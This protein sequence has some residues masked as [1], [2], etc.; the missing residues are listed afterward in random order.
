VENTLAYINLALALGLVGRP[1]SGFGTIT[2][3][4][5]GQ[6]GREHG[7][8][9]DQLPG[10]RR[11]DDPAARRHVAEVWRVPESELPGPGKSAYEMLATLGDEDGVRALLVLGF[12]PAV[13]APDGLSTGGRLAALDFLCVTDFFLSE[14]ARLADVVLPSAQWAEEEGTMTNLE[15]RVIRR[16]RAVAPPDGV[17]TDVEILCGLA[18]RLGAGER[19]TYDRSEDLFDELCR[20]TKGGPADYSGMSY[21]KIEAAGGVFWPCP[22]DEHPGTPRLF[23]NGFPTAGGRAR[24]HTVRHAQADEEPDGTYPL[25][26][27][28]GRV[29]AQ[30]QSGSQTRRIARLAEMAPEPYAELHPAAAKRF[31]V[32][33][34]ELVVLETRR[35]AA[36]FRAK[37]TPEIRED[38][39][40]VPFHWGGEKSANRLTNP[41]LDPFSRMPEFKVCA[42]RIGKAVG[43]RRYAVDSF[44]AESTATIEAFALDTELPTDYRL[45]TTVTGD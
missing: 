10:Y 35:G 20:A 1:R 13:S 29:L 11:I 22:S 34:G 21:A 2:G 19:F 33:H 36:T 6:G 27:T 31:G 9:A 40:F 24:F 3:Q 8:K 7:Q 43:S 32:E 16:R 26:L 18:D 15:G 17:R 23:A 5:N 4:G 45:P 30:Y 12:N 37:V 14:T 39:V 42:V 41:A 25:Y 44:G 38:T 28:T